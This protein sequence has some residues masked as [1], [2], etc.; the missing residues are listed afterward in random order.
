MSKE[1][2]KQLQDNG[3]IFEEP[4]LLIKKLN[5]GSDRFTTCLFVYVDEINIVYINR[6]F[7]RGLETIAEED[8]LRDHNSLNTNTKDDYVATMKNLSFL[9][10]RL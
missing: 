1:K 9:K 3:F 2:V 8:V 6:Y 7:I 4:N 10:S 5:Q